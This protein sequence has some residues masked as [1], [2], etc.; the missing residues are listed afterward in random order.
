MVD[1]TAGILAFD[2]GWNLIRYAVFRDGR[3]SIPGTVATPTD[4]AEAFYRTLA[5]IAA[6]QRVPLAG[7]AISMPGFIDVTHGRAILAGPLGM[8]NRHDI[9]A[10]LVTHLDYP[11]P[12][13]LE[14]DANCAALAE[15]ADG[16]AR[17][18]DDFVLI[19]V[20]TGIGGALFLD[21]HLRR[22]RDWNAGELGMMIT[23]Y[24]SH[25]VL[26]LHDFASMNALAECY[27]QEFGVPREGVVAS[28]LLRRLD[29]PRVR[30]LVERWAD[31]LA[32][33]IYNVA[34]ILDPQCVLLGGTACLE[35]AMMLLVRRALRR[36][37]NWNDFH[38]PVKRCRYVA[39]ACLL[40]AYHAFVGDVVGGDVPV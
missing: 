29:E 18:L 1:G 39:N 9:S 36:L 19:T 26:P 8:L 6:Q 2:V 22:G 13:R 10:E 38:T 24:G 4:S 31:R 5:G 35:P 40:G 11:L 28:S 12:V 3:P 16:N 14:N 17:G 30:E 21:G 7:I 27:A 32:V 34:V 15:K 33:G 37:P 20:D 23:D 25:G